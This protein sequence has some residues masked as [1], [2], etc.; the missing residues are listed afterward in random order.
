MGGDPPRALVD[1]TGVYIIV[2]LHGLTRR[3]CQVE[4]QPQ[5]HGSALDH[6]HRHLEDEKKGLGGA[7]RV[8][9]VCEGAPPLD[10]D[11]RAGEG[12][13]VDIV[14]GADEGPGHKDV[15]AGPAAA[16][17][18]VGIKDCVVV[19]DCEE[20]VIQP[21]RKGVA[22]LMRLLL[23][24]ALVVEPDAASRGRAWCRG[25]CVPYKGV[26]VHGPGRAHDEPAAVGG[27]RIRVLVARTERGR[28]TIR[29]RGCGR[30]F[31]TIPKLLT[32]SSCETEAAAKSSTI[33]KTCS[34]TEIAS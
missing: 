17:D 31:R 33:R 8:V 32:L 19:P 20:G 9:V 11:A 16:L 21:L 7:R 10:G 27:P 22:V 3:A 2:D 12:P 18:A 26:H 29:L 34:S 5:R 6:R 30:K 25:L 28:N 23:R 15:V 4:D 13:E 24:V 1:V 14:A